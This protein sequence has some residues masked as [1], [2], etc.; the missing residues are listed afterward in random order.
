MSVAVG[1]APS[2]PPVAA[3]NGGGAA[4]TPRKTLLIVNTRA[5]DGSA[6]AVAAAAAGGSAR[7]A[8]SIDERIASASGSWP[9]NL[10]DHGERKT[11]PRAAPTPKTGLLIV[12]SAVPR[13]ASSSAASASSLSST[14]WVD[15]DE[16]GDSNIHNSAGRMTV[17]GSRVTAVDDA[18]WRGNWNAV[19]E[20][21]LVD[22]MLEDGTR[23]SCVLHC[24][25]L[26]RVLLPSSSR[27]YS[28][29]LVLCWCCVS[30]G[31][32]FLPSASSLPRHSRRC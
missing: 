3:A 6:A 1:G 32:H 31:W 7:V 11:E 13:P 9:L 14:R 18:V 19:G 27:P 24:L 5:A 22:D 28:F 25:F 29:A 30:C 10:S 15:D 4:I 16:D 20:D 2:P 12:N 8:Q 21:S 17:Y 26:T 23:M